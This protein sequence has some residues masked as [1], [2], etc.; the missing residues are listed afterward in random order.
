MGVQIPHTDWGVPGHKNPDARH[1]HLPFWYDL[2]IENTP[3]TLA[4]LWM[5]LCMPW[6]LFLPPRDEAADLRHGFARTSAFIARRM[7]LK[8]DATFKIMQQG[9]D[10]LRLAF[11]TIGAMKRFQEGMDRIA[12]PRL[13]E[14][15]NDSSFAQA[16]GTLALLANAVLPP[17]PLATRFVP[18]TN[19]Q[20]KTFAV[21]GVKAANQRHLR[22]RA[23]VLAFRA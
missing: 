9:E 1:C 12:R 10:G 7:G 21:N 2:K 13:P 15:Q 4:E 6:A 16:P 23:Q 17:A 18:R 20:E 3:A 14:A 5:R 11:S 19:G 22:P 8:P